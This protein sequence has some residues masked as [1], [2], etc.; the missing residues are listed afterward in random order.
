[1]NNMSGHRRLYEVILSNNSSIQE[2]EMAI[3]SLLKLSFTDHSHYNFLFNQ[4][5]WFEG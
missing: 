1:M 2:K 4:I 3:M 5:N